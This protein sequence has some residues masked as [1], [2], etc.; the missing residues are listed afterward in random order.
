[1]AAILRDSTVSAVAAVV[2]V[3]RTRPPAIPLA[4]ITMRK[5]THEFP[6]LLYI[7]GAPL[8]STSGS[9][10]FAMIFGNPLHLSRFVPSWHIGPSQ[11]FSTPLDWLLWFAPSPTASNLLPAFLSLLYFSKWV[12]VFSFYLLAPSSYSNIAIIIA[13]FPKN[14][15]NHFSS[16]RITPALS[17]FLPVVSSS[18][19]VVT[20]SCHRIRR[21]FHR[22]LLWNT[23]LTLG[24]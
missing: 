2:V 6:F 5:P 16:T 4:M 20:W 8:G 12:L 15:T 11:S 1:M 7:Y 22:H 9:R 13:I 19:F 23:G 21:F 18:S 3:V 24:P 17:G 10:S 14:V